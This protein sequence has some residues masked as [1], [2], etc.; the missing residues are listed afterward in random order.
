MLATRPT[1]GLCTSCYS[2]GFGSE[3]DPISPLTYV[4]VVGA[5]V[6]AN[7][8][9]LLPFISDTDGIW[10]DHSSGK[11]ASIDGVGFLISG[12]NLGAS[13]Y[14]YVPA[15]GLQ[16]TSRFRGR[17][18][19]FE[20]L[21]YLLLLVIIRC[22]VWDSVVCRVFDRARVSLRFRFARGLV[23]CRPS[24][25]VTRRTRTAVVATTPRTEATPAAART[26]STCSIR[27]TLAATVQPSRHYITSTLPELRR[28]SCTIR[29]VCPP[30]TSYTQPTTEQLIRLLSRHLATGWR[31]LGS[32]LPKLFFSFKK[33]N[34]VVVSCHAL[35][36]R[37]RSSSLY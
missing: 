34:V 11:Y 20:V 33:S 6:F 35:S 31:G 12:T 10:Q 18:R 4:V 19:L 28:L 1:H 15:S 36:G 25:A 27:V 2:Y 17:W 3:S 30:A 16:Q 13:P 26:A 21:R 9:K 32:C 23:F 14:I 7:A 8:Y 22:R 29:P 5:T 24:T 37:W